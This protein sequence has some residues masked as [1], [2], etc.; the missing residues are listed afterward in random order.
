MPTKRKTV[1]KPQPQSN[2]EPRLDAL[3]DS[4]FTTRRTCYMVPAV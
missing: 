3:Q 1:K 2:P 4:Y